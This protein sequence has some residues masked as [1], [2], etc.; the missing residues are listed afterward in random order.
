MIITSASFPFK[1]MEFPVVCCRDFPSTALSL[2]SPDMT[3]NFEIR[4]PG[5]IKENISQK[6]KRRKRKKYDRGRT[7]EKEKKTEWER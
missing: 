3:S 6:R 1:I 5:T 2:G 7:G 4:L